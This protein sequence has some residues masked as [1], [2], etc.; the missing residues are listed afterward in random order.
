MALRLV[1]ISRWGFD[2]T[3]RGVSGSFNH[4]EI[5]PCHLHQ[6]V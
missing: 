1:R 5:D 2:P 6:P 4:K 3:G